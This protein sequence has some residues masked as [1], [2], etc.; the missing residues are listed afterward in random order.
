MNRIMNYRL[1]REDPIFLMVEFPYFRS[2]V[3]GPIIL[4]DKKLLSEL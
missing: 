3:I 1:T 4:Q 2:Y